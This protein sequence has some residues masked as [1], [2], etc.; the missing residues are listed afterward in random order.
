MMARIGDTYAATGRTRQQAEK[1]IKSLLDAEKQGPEAVKK[2]RPCRRSSTVRTPRRRPRPTR[3]RRPPAT[4]KPP[5][6]RG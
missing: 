1:D 4:P 6:M 2:D 5:A 3:R